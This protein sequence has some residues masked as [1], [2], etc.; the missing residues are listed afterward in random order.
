[1]S[2]SN[3]YENDLMLLAFNNTAIANI[4]DAAGLRATTTP[5]SLWF[6]LHTADPGEAG[7]AVTSECAHA[8]YARVAVAR[9]GAG[10]VV[11]NSSVSPA[12]NVDFPQAGAG[13]NE[14]AT[15]FGIV[16][17]A[18]GAGKLLYSGIIGSGP[19]VF[20]ALASSDLVTAYAHGFTTDDRVVFEAIEGL[21]LPTGITQG[22]RYFVLASGLTTDAFKVST[23]SGGAALDITGDGGG[24]VYKSLA[25]TITQNVTP[26]LTTGTTVT[27]G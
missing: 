26:R 21:S 2:K 27:E 18:S 1:M 24:L 11:T 25:I 14:V 3:T 16:N 4:G 13:A 17:T 8:N 12:A 6:S 7:T 9:S 19:K 20:T 23:T 15:H 22:T 5:G 10:F